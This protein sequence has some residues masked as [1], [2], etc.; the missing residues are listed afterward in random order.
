MKIQRGS[1][2]LE[3]RPKRKQPQPKKVNPKDF[4][5]HLKEAM[6]AVLYEKFLAKNR[7]GQ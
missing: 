6:G 2:W 7:G 3:E 4:E 5:A 1:S